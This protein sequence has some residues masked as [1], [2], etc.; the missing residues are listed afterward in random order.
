MLD[1]RKGSTLTYP[2][3]D[4]TRPGPDWQVSEDEGAIAAVRRRK[5][6]RLVSTNCG[7]ST[8]RAIPTAGSLL[9][10]PRLSWTSPTPPTSSSGERRDHKQAQAEGRPLCRAGVDD[11]LSTRMLGLGDHQRAS[12][13]AEAPGPLDPRDLGGGRGPAPEAAE[14]IAQYGMLTKS[15]TPGCRYNRPTSRFSTSRRRSC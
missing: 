9:R 5:S 1:G 8:A 12:R 14:K 7:Y 13:T 15:P 6:F 3:C 10:G 11:R 4:R 2:S